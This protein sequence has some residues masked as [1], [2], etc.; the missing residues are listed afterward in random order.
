M[1]ILMETFS[2]ACFSAT[3]HWEDGLLSG[4]D[5]APGL[6]PSTRPQSPF[7]V[8]LALIVENYALLDKDEW[9]E[10]PLATLQQFNPDI[11]QDVFEQALTLEA[12]LNARNTLGGT[13][14]AQVQAQLARHAQRLQADQA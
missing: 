10:L 11:Q 6:R 13:A 12:S 3:F 8:E 7:G 5:L 1:H 2:N 14:P 9:P 4:I